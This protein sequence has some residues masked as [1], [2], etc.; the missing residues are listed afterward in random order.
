ME[1]SEIKAHPKKSSQSD[2]IL[3]YVSEDA[4]MSTLSILIG[5][6]GSEENLDS[7]KKMVGMGGSVLEERDISDTSSVK[8]ITIREAITESLFKGISSASSVSSKSNL[9]ASNSERSTHITDLSDESIKKND[10]FKTPLFRTLSSSSVKSRKG[11]ESCSDLKSVDSKNSS[12][13]IKTFS[14]I[15]MTSTKEISQGQKS[16]ASVS[17]PKLD[18][19]VNEIEE[20]KQKKITK[21]KSKLFTLEQELKKILDDEQMRKHDKKESSIL[22]TNEAPL[23]KPVSVRGISRE[24]SS[25]ADS[26]DKSSTNLSKS[27]NIKTIKVDGLKNVIN[28][29]KSKNP[30]ERE[31]FLS[32]GASQRS[33]DDMSV[34]GLSVLTGLT[35]LTGFT[36]LTGMTGLTGVTGVTGITGITGMTM[37]SKRNTKKRKIVIVGAGT[38]ARL[39]CDAILLHPVINSKDSNEVHGVSNM[40]SRDS[41]S[42]TI[43]QANT[44]SEVPW[45]STLPLTDTS[46]DI[47]NAGN[48]GA[49]ILTAW[50]RNSTTTPIAPIDPRVKTVYGVAESLSDGIVLVKQLSSEN[51]E[52]GGLSPYIEVDFDVIIAATGA[53]MP[54]I[55]PVPGQTKQDRQVE[56]DRVLQIIRNARIDKVKGPPVVIGGGG[57]VAVELAGDMLEAINKERVSHEVDIFKNEI[58]L[59]LVTT[60]DRLLPD[61][62]QLVSDKVTS[63]LQGMGAQVITNDSVMSHSGAFFHDGRVNKVKKEVPRSTLKKRLQRSESQ[64]SRRS[65]ST[66]RYSR[67]MS[68]E[69]I[70]TTATGDDG[71]DDENE[72]ILVLTSGKK[73]LCSAYLP[74]FSGSPNT[75]WI[76]SFG[77]TTGSKVSGPILNTK[78]QIVTDKFLRSV[79]YNKMFAIGLASD[80]NEISSVPM[81]Q[82]QALTIASCITSFMSGEQSREHTPGPFTA[83]AIVKVGK[84]TFALH[85]SPSYYSEEEKQ[86]I[87]MNLNYEDRNRA[88]T[89]EKIL[90]V[91]LDICGFPFNMMCPC[92]CIASTC[93]PLDPMCC[94]ECL[95]PP[96]GPGVAKMIENV[97]RTEMLCRRVGY[98]DLGST[99]NW[100]SPV[101]DF[102][103]MNR[104]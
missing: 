6:A 41:L 85:V 66:N 7:L 49:P 16:S 3:G 50:E 61:Q 76:T 89:D 99:G 75:K 74:A 28:N 104:E 102:R 86:K 55:L 88:K 13:L 43:I 42:I 48:S 24:S 15:S 54:V 12:A 95:S 52:N 69:S 34:A 40:R 77:R 17:T 30:N 5:E 23:K 26:C 38:S 10:T 62:P 70:C 33:G 46:V 35:G 53:S 91:V 9:K 37:S 58:Q 68:R 81:L 47:N 100:T 65:Q 22:D 45:Y 14:S 31:S 39:L 71:N 97:R 64:A 44:W 36:G 21:S 79:S 67:K 11:T 59:I 94:G 84:G 78:G 87:L 73:I 80:L 2:S 1:S 56:V 63:V 8:S 20:S 19:K 90:K 103:D 93:G 27:S 96:E 72:A 51:D 60:S 82:A 18:N 29:N 4:K 98:Y 92:F 101:I 25:I 32:G 83:P 57:P